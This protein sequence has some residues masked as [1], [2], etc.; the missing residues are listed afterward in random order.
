MTELP[1]Q[2][3]AAIDTLLLALD[4]EPQ[5]F[6]ATFS[7][8]CHRYPELLQEPRAWQRLI[9]A[10]LAQSGFPW[11]QSQSLTDNPGTCN[12]DDSDDATGCTNTKQKA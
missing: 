1:T 2:T 9:R 10:T 4:V 7:D 3:I 12:T 11:Q 5:E 6:W 8:N